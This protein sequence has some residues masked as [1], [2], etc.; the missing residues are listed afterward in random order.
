MRKWIDIVNESVAE[1]DKQLPGEHLDAWINR[2]AA[3]NEPLESLPAKVERV[4]ND[5]KFRAWFGDSHVFD[6]QGD[7]MP[8]HHFTWDTFDEFDRHPE[9]FKHRNPESIDRVGFWFTGNPEARYGPKRLDCY[10][11]IEKPLW[12]DDVPGA[13]DKPIPGEC[14]FSQLRDMVEAAGGAN[15]FRAEMKRRGYDGII[16]SGTG[17]DGWS[18]DVYI[19]FDPNQI[20]SVNNRGTWDRNSN[21]LM[22]SP[23]DDLEADP[24]IPKGEE[25][26]WYGGRLVDPELNIKMHSSITVWPEHYGVLSEELGDG[27]YATK[28]EAEAFHQALRPENI[29]R[30]WQ[31][32]MIPHSDLITAQSHVTRKGLEKHFQ[33]ESQSP[34]LVYRYVLDQDNNGQITNMV[35]DGN[36]R[37][38]ADALKGLTETRCYVLDLRTWMDD[39]GFVYGSKHPDVISGKV[40]NI[41]DTLGLR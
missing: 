37:L 33:S 11:R 7:P 5:P 39:E 8:V 28:E 30:Y 14:C 20:K 35:M 6:G 23:L 2:V 22:E 1:E 13:D 9:R 40:P 27:T 19:V 26:G 31:R 36:H 25:E 34:V 29:K 15:K 10:L 12:L 24:E 41:L 16:M 3:R 32:E 17:L 38:M 21:R 4:T 18:Q